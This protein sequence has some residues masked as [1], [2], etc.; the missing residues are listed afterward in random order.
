MGGACST[1]CGNG[2]QDR[3]VDIQ[4]RYGGRS[5]PG[6]A[7]R[8]CNVRPCPKKISAKELKDFHLCKNWRNY[9]GYHIPNPDNCKTY[10]QCQVN[11]RQKG[12]YEA[13]LKYC[14]K[15]TGFDPS[16][17]ICNNLMSSCIIEQELR[18]PCV[19]QLFSQKELQGESKG[20][21]NRSQWVFSEDDDDD[22]DDDDDENDDNDDN[23]DDYDDDDDDYDDDYDD[24]DNVKS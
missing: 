11:D 19:L 14:G 24:D 10:Y 4:A 22:D 3:K 15:G 20:Q 8:N 17:G 1:T 9:P 7:R 5:C 13:I 23:D 12:G 16:Q 18:T 21:I 2:N 6:D